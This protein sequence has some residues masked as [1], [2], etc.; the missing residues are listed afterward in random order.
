M[1]LPQDAVVREPDGSTT[2]WVTTD[3]RRFT[4]RVVRVGLQ[5]DG[6]DQIVDGVQPGEL[7]V[8]KGAVFLDNMLSGG[9]S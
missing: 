3:R 4:Q 5:R 6:Y 1:T 2:A 9:L 7:I 8:T